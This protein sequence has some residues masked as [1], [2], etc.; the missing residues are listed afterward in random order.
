MLYG[1]IVRRCSCPASR[2]VFPF[3]WMC[4]VIFAKTKPRRGNSARTDCKYVVL[5]TC[6]A[7]HCVRTDTVLKN[8]ATA[9]KPQNGRTNPPVRVLVLAARQI[10]AAAL[11]DFLGSMQRGISGKGSGEAACL[12]LS[13]GRGV[14]RRVLQASFTRFH[15]GAPRACRLL[16]GRFH[17]SLGTRRRSNRVNGRYEL[18]RLSSS[19]SRRV[20]SFVNGHRGDGI[21]IVASRILNDGCRKW[22]VCG[23]PQIWNVAGLEHRAKPEHEEPAYARAR[24]KIQCDGQGVFFRLRIMRA[25]GLHATSFAQCGSAAREATPAL[26]RV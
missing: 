18:T 26:S 21:L 19:T 2:R 12:D 15:C 8:E 13:S 14:P 9:E 20:G 3:R 5:E 24:N 22:F 17:C 1:S 11:R 23:H 6:S 10:G 7:K 4:S 25:H 16:G